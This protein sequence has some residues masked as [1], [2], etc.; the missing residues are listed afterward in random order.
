MFAFRNVCLCQS[1]KSYIY[2]HLFTTKV[3]FCKKRNSNELL[4]GIL[5]CQSSRAFTC[6][7]LNFRNS[8]AEFEK[9]T[10]PSGWPKAVE[11]SAK[12][13]AKFQRKPSGIQTNTWPVLVQGPRWTKSRWVDP[14]GR[15]WTEWKTNKHTDLP[16]GQEEGALEGWRPDAGC[17][18]HWDP[19]IL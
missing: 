11:L 14:R 10:L 15:G 8:C 4:A 6:V 17:D 5:S 13:C 12:E 16:G 19:D 18:H 7:V 2:H 3:F 1:F 9:K